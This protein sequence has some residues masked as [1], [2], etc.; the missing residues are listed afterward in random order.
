[1]A[2][3]QVVRKAAKRPRTRTVGTEGAITTEEIADLRE[4]PPIRYV[5]AR[6]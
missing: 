6:E 2:A 1:V 5:V 3:G 4:F